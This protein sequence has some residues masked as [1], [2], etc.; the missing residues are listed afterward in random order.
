M[1]RAGAAVLPRQSFPLAARPQYVHDS[2]KHPTGTHSLSARARPAFVLASTDPFVLRYQRPDTFPQSIRYGPRLKC[3]HEPYC[4]TQTA[5]GKM[6]LRISS[7]SESA[8]PFGTVG[9]SS[10]AAPV[11]VLSTA[12]A[13]VSGRRPEVI[14]SVTGATGRFV[15]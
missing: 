1:Y 8:S 11:C 2:L 6:Y 15:S 4:S 5:R 3:T 9:S 14:V 7:K 12:D 10:T 13:E